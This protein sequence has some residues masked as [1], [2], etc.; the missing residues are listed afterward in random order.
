[1]PFRKQSYDALPALAIR[2]DNLRWC[3]RRITMAWAV[4]TV[5]VTVAMGPCME[6][7]A[8]LIGGGNFT[9]GLIAAIPSM[10]AILQL[11]A[12]VLIER[13]GLTKFQFLAFGTA[14]RLMFLL[15]A[16]IP[17]VLP[18]P[19]RA[20]VAALLVL[21][22]LSWSFDAFARPAWISWMGVLIPPRIRGRYLAR[23]RQITTLVQTFAAVGVALLLDRR[24]E[25]DFAVIWPYQ[26]RLGITIM[27]LFV[28]AGACGSIDIL[29]FGKIP[30]VI[31]HKASAPESPVHPQATKRP[32]G[33]WR[34][35]RYLLLDPMRDRK[36]RTY[37]LYSASTMCATTIGGFF[38]YRNMI[39]NVLVG[40]PR[41]FL[42]TS[43]LFLVAGPIAGMLAARVVG[44]AVDRY[45]RR[46][47]LVLGTIMTLTSIAPWFF[48]GPDMPGWLIISIVALGPI[49]GWMAWGAIE[50][51][52]MNILLSFADG[53]GRSR[54][55]AASQLYISL[56]GVIGGLAAAVLTSGFVFLQDNPLRIG[57]FLYN[58]WHVAFAASF[59]MRIVAIVMA[60]RLHDPGSTR[61]RTVAMMAGTRAVA[62]MYGGLSYPLRLFGWRAPD[63]RRPDDS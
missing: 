1:M 42:I 28:V 30:E 35:I 53:D 51:T 13:T 5:W 43:V 40:W 33:R 21:L 55:V 2:G 34:L 57:P 19:S 26:V 62:T 50:M 4:G 15:M 60:A 6:R 41:P 17:L 63:R 25:N 61:A 58:N 10:A 20:A 56:G 14:H 9:L 52:K 45:G 36:F 11:W 38:F 27:G 8:A 47:V 37:V 3:L 18:V 39:E 32:G 48:L 12:T 16:F 59:L 31:A 49:L 22:L 23:R 24:M 54:Y 44:R 7:Y 46:P 29:L